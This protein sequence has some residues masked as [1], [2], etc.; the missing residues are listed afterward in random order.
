MTTSVKLICG[1]IFVSICLIKCDAENLI[2]RKRFFNSLWSSEAQSDVQDGIIYSQLP[3]EYLYLLPGVNDHKI[4]QRRAGDQPNFQQSPPSNQQPLPANLN[5]VRFVHPTR[6]AIL[7]Q[8]PKNFQGNL[9]VPPQTQLQLQQQQQGPKVLMRPAVQTTRL[10][11]SIALN[12]K[13][14]SLPDIYKNQRFV[15]PKPVHS[16]TQKNNVQP[17]YTQQHLPI[18]KNFDE[19][20]ILITKPVLTVK[21]A[22]VDDFYQTKEFQ[23]LLSDYKIKVDVSKLPPIKDIMA[24]LGTENCEDTLYAINDVVKSP[25][26]MELIKSYLD[27]NPDDDKFYN[28]DE[29]VG[30]GEI[31]VEGSQD[32]KFVQPQQPLIYP[33]IPYIAPQPQVSGIPTTI[34]ASTTGDL[35]GQD[36]SA[37]WKPSSWFSSSPST[38]VESAQKDAE[39][40]KKVVVQGGLSGSPWQ[41][42]QY[43][44]NFFTS[45][46]VSGEKPLNQVPVIQ[47]PPR[48]MFLQQPISQS[49]VTGDTKVLPAV[50]MTEAQFQDMVK[51]LRLTPMNSQGLQQNTAIQRPQIRVNP[52]YPLVALLPPPKTAPAIKTTT[53]TTTTTT[54]PVPEPETTQKSAPPANK[55]ESPINV[56]S[57]NTRFTQVVPLP[58]TFTQEIPYEYSP[59]Q[60][61]SQDNRRNFVSASE[62]QRSAP[63]DFIATGRVHNANPDEVHKKSRSL[64]ETL[65]EGETTSFLP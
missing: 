62:P 33:R 3:P 23:D 7:H 42:V 30:A 19:N 54:T 37:W 21:T 15:Q 65:I 22:A 64:V 8:Q 48:R 36:K 17:F 43:V 26:G 4:A 58:S 60:F 27:Q 28:Y 1:I 63:Y 38:S 55:F 6:M 9:K 24:I 29:D 45:A 56:Q 32:V 47:G 25:E 39:I 59:Q 50:R 16:L 53:A 61:K 35:V 14:Q 44:R 20:Q 34:R 40:L 10:Q 49:Q 52:S 5:P 2:R 13:E 12:T 31:Q 46:S 57:L 51:A 18:K 41:N 11:P